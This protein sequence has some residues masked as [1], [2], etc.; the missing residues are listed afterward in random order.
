MNHGKANESVSGRKFRDIASIR[1]YITLEASIIMPFLIMIIL[2]SVVFS[3]FLYNNCVVRQSSYI[4][5]LRGIQIMN[6]TSSD[7]KSRVENYAQTLLDNQIYEYRNDYSVNV[8][9]LKVSVQA[10]SDMNNLFESFDVY[11]QSKLVIDKKA[12][13]LRIDPVLLI[14]IKY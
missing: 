1:G 12:E 13:G 8:D 14:R 6:S 4:S 10:K 11:N 7:V 9:S 5:A 2:F 3:F